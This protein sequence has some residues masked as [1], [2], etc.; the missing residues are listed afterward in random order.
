MT[1]Y[2]L[3]TE[4]P[5]RRHL[6]LDGDLN[7]EQRAVVLAPRGPVLVIA[8]AGSGKT[9]TLTY[10][11]AHLLESGVP[12]DRLLLCTFTHRAAREMVRRVE[13]LLEIDL[14]PLW[15]GT[16]H[17]VAN[18][19]LRRYAETVGL[20]PNYAI[21]DRED[22]KD[23]M[24]SCLSEEG[25]ALRTRRFPQPGLLQHLLSMSV[26]S[27]AGISEVVRFHA[28]R[29]AEM[30]DDIRRV[31]DRFVARKLSLGLVD[32][33]DL[34]L[35]FK[36]LLTEHPGPAAELKDRFEHVLV[37]EYQDTS[38][39]QGEIV[40]ACAEKHGS[41]TVVGDDAQS[42]YGF[43]GAD[44]RNII[45]FPERH[46]GT[47]LLKLERNYRSTPEILALANASIAVNRRQFPKVLR[48]V[49]PPGSM[50]ALLPL[51]DADQQ[52]TFVAQRVLELSQEEG[53]PL[54]DIGVLYRAHSHSLEL[55]VEL[56]RRGIPFTIRSGLRF[57]EQAHIKD[58]TA[59]L[60]LA[61][62]GGDELAW[63]RVLGLWP[64][65]GQKT[66]E[67]V[68]AAALVSGG[69][70][71]AAELL[72]S[73]ELR[74]RLP[75]T[76]GPSMVRLAELLSRLGAFDALPR[77]IDAVVETHYRE[78]AQASFAN[79]E[80][81]LEDLRQLGDFASRYDSLEE[82][83]SEL[84]IVAG[85]AAE[86][87]KPGEAPEEKLTLSTVHQAKGLEWRAVFVLWLAEGRFPQ[88]LGL[89]TQAEEEEERRLFHV[90][91]TR[92]KEQLY[93]CHPRFEEPRE[94]PRRLLRLSRFLAEH[95]HDARVPYERWEIEVAAV[96][97]GADGAAPEG[98]VPR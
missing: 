13:A 68:L 7:D 29:F 77:M 65:A 37:D 33:D 85:M 25:R 9:R 67:Q 47:V 20:R 59:Y 38:R 51:E 58:V 88:A 84:A 92:A 94:G 90:A 17:H 95:S 8:G 1:R 19:A 14:R 43:R 26:D 75:K 32:Y 3:R 42:I 11:A 44:F 72:R 34:Q 4:R 41:L 28:P 60:R 46:E 35:F 39:I 57:F 56:A 83:L 71:P 40:D 55:Q 74:A 93:L 24:A 15:A 91:V 52:A 96:D 81:R 66:A 69:R 80:V 23:L 87:I 21:L 62:N 27:Q 79:S 76:A 12:P 22:S 5:P 36:I 45:E 10:R 6:D 16:F 70:R 53:V 73:S 78:Y 48:A 49:R 30:V 61:H 82:F 97:A 64:G 50:P 54:G 2:I 31:L 98:E 63:R 89:R 18:L 86:G